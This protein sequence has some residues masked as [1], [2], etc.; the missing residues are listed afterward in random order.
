VERRPVERVRGTQDFWPVEAQ[1]LE[2]VRRRLEETFALFGY[3]RLDLPVLESAELH[4]R[5]SGLDIIS[6]LYAFDDQGGRRLCLRPE[7]TA[8]VV[9]ACISQP[10]PRLPLKVF[11]SGAVFRY[12]RPSRGR[13]RQFTHADVELIGAHGTLADGELIFMAMD[14]VDRLGLAEYRVTVGHVGILAQ[15][16]TQLGLSGRLRTVLLDS[17][18]EARRQG[19]AAVRAQLRELDPDLFESHG[20][21]DHAAGPAA[22]DE[23]G[24]DAALAAP[25]DGRAGQ[26]GQRG[27][28]GE[29]GVRQAAA[30]LLSQLGASSL[31]RRSEEEI[32]SRLLHRMRTGSQQEAV[33]RA[34]GFIAQ[35]GAIRGAPAAVL[36]AGRELLHAY[37]L[38]DEPLT[39]LEAT[40]HHLSAFGA[41]LRKVELDLG[42]SRGL[43]Y[44]TGM[45]FELHHAG[46]G[47]E[48]QLCGGG[49]YDDL[50]R[51]LGSRQSIPAAG[52]AFGAERVKLAL[53]AEGKLAASA[54][55]A[56][57]LVVP[58]APAFDGYAARV[59]QAVRRCGCRAELDVAGRTLRATLAY[60]DR[61]GYPQVIVVGEAEQRDGTVR[62]R[63]MASGTE[64]IIP[65]AELAAALTDLPAAAH[66]GGTE[67]R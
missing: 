14:A 36:D 2:E 51:A 5:K 25:R 22:P 43:Q 46:L 55:V 38:G 37:G 40:M 10:P 53:A 57:L 45:V 58:A 62:L 34:L 1:Q 3:R 67:N 9:R 59:A 6:K 4:L 8:S 64:R 60:A 39:E 66:H 26:D 41:D 20:P 31:G 29:A 15:L 61:E 21:T 24:D 44:Y 17:R 30:G 23:P 7:V 33:E 48:T 32:V 63:A 27:E 49:R 54:A 65:L 56:D 19:L 35:L 28:I 52:F 13:Y 12:E 47:S 11:S 18:E 16:L 50:F 42:L